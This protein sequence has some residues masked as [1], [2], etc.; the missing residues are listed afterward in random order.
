MLAGSFAVSTSIHALRENLFDYVVS[1]A[2]D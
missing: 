1:V 2:F